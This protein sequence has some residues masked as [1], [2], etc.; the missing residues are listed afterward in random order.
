MYQ[1]EKASHRVFAH[2]L[3]TEFRDLW[4]V[5]NRWVTYM[6]YKVKIKKLRQW[7]EQNKAFLVRI[8]AFHFN[9]VPCELEFYFYHWRDLRLNKFKDIFQQTSTHFVIRL[10]CQNEEVNVSRVL[11]ILWLLFVGELQAYRSDKWLSQT[12]RLSGWWNHCHPQPASDCAVL[13]ISSTRC[14]WE[15]SG[16]RIQRVGC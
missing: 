16:T 11:C 5:L 12:P 2:Y 13:S 10:G 3:E 8:L 6:N 7:L 15:H 4:L 9:V 14:I 1:L